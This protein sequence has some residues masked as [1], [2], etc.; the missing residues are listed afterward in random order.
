MADPK[1]IV[2]YKSKYGTT[3]R[4]AEWIAEEV[5]ADLFEQSAVSVED[6][7]KYDIIV[8]GGSLH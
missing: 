6:L 8:Y 1:I 2:V 7:L 3:K 4:Y 5:K